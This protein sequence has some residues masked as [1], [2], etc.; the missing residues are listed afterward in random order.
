MR[1]A[2]SALHSQTVECSLLTNTFQCFSGADT[3]RTRTEMSVM[4]LYRKTLSSISSS[5]PNV[6]TKHRTKHHCWQSSRSVM[7]GD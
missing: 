2:S 1:L 6:F 4:I 7:A 5:S 3:G